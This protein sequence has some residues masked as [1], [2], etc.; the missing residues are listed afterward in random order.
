[1]GSETQVHYSL[2]RG[3]TWASLKLNMPTV[4]ISDLVIKGNDLVV[5]T[6]GRSCWILDDLTPIRLFSPLP[7]GEGPG[8]KSEPRFFPITPTTRWRYHGE[9]YALE[10]RLPG[11]NP[12]KGALLNYYLPTKP[13]EDV[14]LEIFDEKGTLVQ[15]L[16]SKKSD[17][18]IDEDSPDVPWSIFKPTILPKEPGMNR[19]A[20]NLEMMGPTII[21]GAKNDGGVPYRGPMVLPGTYTLMLRIDGKVLTQK[22][23]VKIDPRFKGPSTDLAE[24]HKL[25]LQLRDDITKLSGI[26][27]ALQSARSQIKERVKV[28]DGNTKA[29]GWI[30][31]AKEVVAKL[32]ALEEQLH[33]P[34]AEVTYD[35]L[36]K[37]GG[38]KLY[39]QLGPLY[40]TVK[41]SD[42]PATQG[43][44]EVYAD[45]AK[46]LA[47]LDGE[48]RRVLAE[49][50]G[51]LNDEAKQLQ[52]PAIIVPA[53]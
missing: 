42:G 31:Q 12:A 24:S 53:K 21:P 28:L 11:D 36:A 46:E 45:N 23:E 51:R 10:D 22:V 38:A 3:E 8:V 16:S 9:N 32:D 6:S 13:K 34:K 29:D 7:L 44:R 47:R 35:I 52:Q 2:D 33:N 27:I 5:G 4:A 43:M 25:A 26:V 19:V 50:I 39:S 41:D 37:K 48:W 1:V 18:V 14:A 49:Q 15:K 17:I 40:D 20:W 30:K